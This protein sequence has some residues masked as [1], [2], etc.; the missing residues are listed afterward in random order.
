MGNLIFKNHGIE[1]LQKFADFAIVAADRDQFVS[2][3]SQSEGR[4]N[5]D[6]TNS[7]LKTAQLF[8]AANLEP[9]QEDDFHFDESNMRFVEVFYA[10]EDSN[11]NTYANRSYVTQVY[12]DG[13]WQDAAEGL[14]NT[15]HDHAHD[16]GPES[17]QPAEIQ[18]T[19]VGGRSIY[20]DPN[21]Q[22]GHYL[23]TIYYVASINT[24]TRVYINH[25][26]VGLDVI[27]IV[28]ES[29]AVLEVIDID[30]ADY[31]DVR[32]YLL[33]NHNIE[34]NARPETEVLTQSMVIDSAQVL[35]AGG[36]LILQAED[37]FA[38]PDNAH[39][40]NH[41]TADGLHT[42]IQFAGHDQTR[43]WLT[44]LDDGTLQIADI[45]QVPS[46]LHEIYVSISD[47]AGLLEGAMI[48][49]AID[50]TVTVGGI[51]YD[52]QSGLELE[53][54]SAGGSA[55]GFF[56]QVVT[57]DDLPVSF[58]DHLGVRI[59][60]ASGLPSGFAAGVITT[61]LADP[62]DH[63]VMKFFAIDYSS[64]EI[65]ELAVTSTGEDSFSL[66]RG[67]QVLADMTIT[68]N[69]ADD[70]STYIDEMYV[71]GLEDV[72]LGIALNIDLEAISLHADQ[73]IEVTVET[74][75]FREA[76]YSGEFGF[77][78]ADLQS[79]FLIDPQSGV[80]LENLGLTPENV[81][82]YGVISFDSPADTS[83]QITSSFL[84]DADLN[85]NNLA[86]FPYYQVQTHQGN[87][88]FLGGASGM[89]DGISHIAR[90]AQN[91]F[92][93]ED[94][95]GADYDFDD[96]MVTINSISVTGFA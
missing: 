58:V 66:S 3:Y 25:F 73:P 34:L 40:I 1:G 74:T 55:I 87:Q 56:A 47:E 13:Q 20:S 7:T 90:I 93:V 5:W 33:E 21:W 80:L 83:A 37:F 53:L 72:L 91:T 94:L 10:Q 95:V 38:D 79:G 15:H 60:D 51:E 24:G 27:H 29:G 26:D 68:E 54:R 2:T 48:T 8:V 52:P 67:D 78:L 89:H 6:S 41:S 49:L 57:E 35:A 23:G 76:F 85:L 70:P 82:Q 9:D 11:F 32:K 63:G 16:Y 19:S 61:N 43:S 75:A 65:F 36:S 96:F 39:T 12:V 28:D 22:E 59:G 62:I 81:S 86:L 44:L 92:G 46:G 64:Q 77:L 31:A 88:L 69:L 42:R 18:H 14:I 30:R 17:F 45:N 50:P 4:W 71:N 84:L